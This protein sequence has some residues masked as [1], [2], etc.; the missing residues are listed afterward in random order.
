LL[1]F[2]R[3][4]FHWWLLSLSMQDDTTKFIQLNK[5]V[6][7]LADENN[8]L[9]QENDVL[10]NRVS[11]LQELAQ[12]LRD[13]IAVLKGQ[14]PRPKF[15][16]SKLEDKQNSSD[17]SN[18]SNTNNPSSSKKSKPG[19]PKGKKRKKKKTILEIHNEIVLQPTVIPE[20]SIFKG[21]R[22]YSV[23]DITIR[24]NNTR[25]LRARYQL[26]DGSYIEGEL[27]PDI[28]R[29]YGPELITYILD[30]CHSCRVTEP[31]LLTQLHARGV[32]ISAGQLN[33]ILIQNN[34]IYEQEVNELL[35]AGVEA[36]NQ[37]QVDD[38]GGRHDGDNQY[39]TIIGNQWFSVFTTTDSKSR[40]NF[41][42]LLQGNKEHYLINEDTIAYLKECK[43]SSYLPGYIATCKKAKYT[44]LVA[45]NECVKEI[46]VTQANDVRFLTE[47]ALF[48][49]LF[50]HGIPR[51]LLIHS[52]DAGQFDVALFI[53]T[54]CWI[55]EE[56]HYRKLIMTT[57]KARAELECVKEQI[58]SFYQT[59]KAYKTNP[60]K[61]IVAAIEK[62]FDDI[63]QQKTS[64][65]TLDHQL[66]KTHEKKK[67]LLGVLKR[68]NS[69]LHNNRSE[70]DARAAKIKLKVSGGTRSDTGRASRDIFLSLK[71]TCLK[72]GINFI[73]F[74][75]DRVRGLYNIPRLAEIIRKRSLAAVSDPPSTSFGFEIYPLARAI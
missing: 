46:N 19:Q 33:N 52:D 14:K 39:T 41:L 21:Y 23:Q 27:P 73:S 29:H 44:T 25:Y 61:Q 9:R 75:Q 8:Q 49:S 58:W 56:R 67:E 31:L 74:L 2:S 57:D 18:S 16:P 50:E 71:Q 63:F 70:T 36:D 22:P 42:K 69:P 64:S 7:S 55:H 72:L 1:K 51:D 32:L 20:G 38:T 66:K 28:H 54:L 13:E 60:D 30:Q 26:L 62:K 5:V 48:A 34:A 10:T 3:K 37:V 35:A 15:P 17:Q 53:N 40:I 47:A 45:W 65:P 68:P 24:T 59:L 12:Q 11:F 6:L 4:Y 43:S